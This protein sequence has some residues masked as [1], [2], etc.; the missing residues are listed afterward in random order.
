MKKLNYNYHDALLERVTLADATLAFYI[1]LYPVF[2]P[3]AP[4]IKLTFKSVTEQAKVQKWIEQLEQ[5][6]EQTADNVYLRI[7]AVKLLYNVA[8]SQTLYWTIE[9]DHMEKLHFQSIDFREQQISKVIPVDEQL[10]IICNHILS[11][12]LSI[13]SWRE[14]ESDDMF[15]TE[16]YRGGFDAVEN[17]FVFSYY[18]DQEYWFQLSIQ[19]VT[20]IVKGKL[21]TVRGIMAKVNKEL[22]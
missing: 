15:Q 3:G 20:T 10:L 9:C 5:E 12:N 13:E 4:K 22:K 11:E 17:E 8:R 6:L 16:K 18:D 1:E 19:Q 21:K 14:I 7:D 2:Y